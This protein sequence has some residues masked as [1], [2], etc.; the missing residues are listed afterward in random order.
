MAGE[1]AAGRKVEIRCTSWENCGK[2]GF[3]LLHE[4]GLFAIVPWFT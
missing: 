2:R 1:K 4:Q 3:S